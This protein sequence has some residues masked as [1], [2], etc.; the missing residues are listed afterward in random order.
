ML[1]HVPKDRVEG[2]GYNRAPY[3]PRRREI[4]QEYADLIIVGLK[5]PA[6]Q[7]GRPIRYAAN[8]PEGR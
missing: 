7:L 2:G 5:A 3:I 1:A 4:A 6:A 8:G